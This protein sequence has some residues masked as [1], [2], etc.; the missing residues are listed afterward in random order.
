MKSVSLPVSWLMPWSDMIN[1]DPGV[2]NSEIRSTTS[3]AISMR[4]KA[5]F[6][7]NLIH[8]DE[9]RESPKLTRWLR[10]YAL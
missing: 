10:F 7:E 1:D 2:S 3:C 8:V 5:A 6:T 9:M 4:S